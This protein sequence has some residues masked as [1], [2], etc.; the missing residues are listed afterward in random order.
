MMINRHRV[1][2]IG[3]GG[4]GQ[5][6]V[7]ALLDS[8][9]AEVGICDFDENALLRLEQ[10]FHVRGFNSLDTALEQ[11]WDAAVVAT[12]AH[13]HLEIGLRLTEMGISVLVEKP[14]A[15]VPDGLKDWAE[16]ATRMNVPVMVGFVFRCH[17]ILLAL[18]RELQNG[19]IGRPLQIVSQRGGHLPSRR[20]DYISNYYRDRSTG[21]GVVQ[22][23][24]SHVLNATE[25]LVGPVDQVMASAAHL[26][27]PGVEVDDTVSV[28]AR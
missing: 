25:W 14:L 11:P 19:R 1:L 2:V 21:G 22:D 8:G 9:R 17:P 20:P 23:I 6:H 26:Q 3:V 15:L 4:I 10:K 24:L 13:S 12:P 27:L 7:E 28:I 18:R 16:A 5:V